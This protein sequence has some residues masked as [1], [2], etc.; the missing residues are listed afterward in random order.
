MNII[1]KARNMFILHI[2]FQRFYNMFTWECSCMT[3]YFKFICL[4][5]KLFQESLNKTS[6]LVI[7]FKNDIVVNDSKGMLEEQP[8]KIQLF[9]LL[10]FSSWGQGPFPPCS[11]LYPQPLAQC[12][13]VVDPQEIFLGLI[14][15]WMQWMFLLRVR[16]WR[17]V[18]KQ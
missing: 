5:L 8:P 7:C 17:P 9:N 3:L 14:N 13:H 15:G 2:R 1:A 12:W 16:E 6:F 11:S 10:H 4:Y 18:F